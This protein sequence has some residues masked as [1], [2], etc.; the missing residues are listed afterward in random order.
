MALAMIKV[1]LR[2]WCEGQA[3]APPVCHTGRGIAG[4]GESWW[5]GRVA[6]ADVN[7]TAPGTSQGA[8]GGRTGLGSWRTLILAVVFF[9]AATVVYTFPFALHPGSLLLAGVG[10]HPTE[11]A[12]IGWTARQ[13]LHAPAHLFETEFFY[14]H[15]RTEAYPVKPSKKDTEG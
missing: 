5:N 8:P 10:D 15:S 3:R 12:L 14:P 7:A 6:P 2:V 1:D 4:L 9:G 11:A 13:L